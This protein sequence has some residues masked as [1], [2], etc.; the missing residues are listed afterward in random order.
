MIQRLPPVARSSVLPSLLRGDGDDRVHFTEGEKQTCLAPNV[1][2][3]SQGE[4]GE[5]SFKALENQSSA[6]VA[7]VPA[8]EGTSLGGSQPSA[9][10]LGS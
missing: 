1:V 4:V 3:A 7:A 6:L 10:E 9:A 8:A 5:P 2:P